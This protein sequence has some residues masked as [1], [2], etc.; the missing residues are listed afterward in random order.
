VRHKGDD[1]RRLDKEPA[2]SLIQNAQKY[3][4]RCYIATKDARDYI[5]ACQC[6]LD[7]DIKEASCD[8]GATECVRRRGSLVYKMY[9]LVKAGATRSAPQ[10]LSLYWAV[11]KRQVRESTIRTGVHELCILG[12]VKD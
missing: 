5:I 7:M 8:G 10:M 2:V 11:S 12:S 3:D 4:A 1:S 9:V 6:L